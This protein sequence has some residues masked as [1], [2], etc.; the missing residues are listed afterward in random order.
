MEVFTGEKKV[1]AAVTPRTVIAGSRTDGWV[2][3]TSDW[4]IGLYRSYLVALEPLMGKGNPSPP[5]FSLLIHNQP[6][7]GSRSGNDPP[8]PP[9]KMDG[10]EGPAQWAESTAVRYAD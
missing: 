10:L 1:L 8:N 5:L 3:V 9:Q 6:A 4:H 7:Q 2:G